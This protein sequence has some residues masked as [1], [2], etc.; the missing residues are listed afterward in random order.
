[1]VTITN[2]YTAP[3]N[4]PEATIIPHGTI[5]FTGLRRKVRHAYNS[6][7]SLR[8]VESSVSKPTSSLEKSDSKK[9]QGC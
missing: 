4:P 7:Q 2:A 5:V 6:F 3:I 1:M 8:I 9:A